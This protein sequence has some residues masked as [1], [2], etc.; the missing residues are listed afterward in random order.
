MYPDIYF[1]RDFAKVYEEVEGGKAYHLK[2]ATAN[3]V[4]ENNVIL[5]E[6]PSNLAGGPYY[7]LT[8][9]Y[10]YGGPLITELKGKKEAL[11]KDY[12]QMMEEFVCR[13]KVVSEFVRFHPL[14]KNQQ[15]FKSIYP[16]QA[17]SM[18]VATRISKEDTFS[19]QFSRSARKTVRKALRK[20]V[21]YRIVK[22]PDDIAEFKAIYF[23]TMDRNQADDFYY[24]DESYFEKLAAEFKEH[25]LLIEISY[26]KKVVA[27]ALYFVYGDI[28]QAHL[29]GTLT[30]YLW[31]SPA[32]LI[33]YA[34]TQWAQKHRIKW[35]HQGGGRTNSK[36]DPLYRFK[37]RFSQTT[38]PIFFVG[39]K[40]WNNAIY[41][42]LLA[43]K[44]VDESSDF[45]PLYRLP[46]QK[47]LLVLGGSRISMQIVKKAQKKG[48]FT[49]VTDWYPYKDSPAKQI[50]DRCYQVST[51]APEA[52]L[53]LIKKEKI[54]GILT[55]FTDSALPHYAE[56]C[57]LAGLPCY[58]SKELFEL[59]THKERYKKLCR[60]YQIP[61]IDDYHLSWDEIKAGCLPEELQFPL[62]VKPADN[63][64]GRGVSICANQKEL[65]TAYRQALEL[66]ESKTVLVER[67]MEGQEAT[68]FFLLDQGQVYLSAIGNR[69]I[70]KNQGKDTIALPVAYTFPAAITAK[71]I[72]ETLPKMKQMFQD[73]GIRDGMMFVQC[74]V[75]NDQCI[76]YDMGYRLT[77]SLEYFLQK[78]I[79]GFDPLEMLI[80]FAFSNQ[81]VTDQKVKERIQPFWQEY[82][83]NLSFLIQ[84]EKEIQAIEGRK[85]I[86]QHPGVIAAVL[87]HEEGEQLT[88]AAKGTL[89]QIVLRVLGK[90]NSMTD[91]K[92]D[93]AQ[94]Y[95]M[96]KVRDTTGENILLA[97]LDVREITGK[98]VKEDDC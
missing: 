49:V 87:A 80:D 6:I 73:V 2:T 62:L 39:K 37:K 5:R 79:C 33:R 35:I 10:G 1:A 16:I 55:G 43:E 91:L 44:T 69:H 70:K 93:L 66:S 19:Q 76:L 63:S 77:G 25:L 4:I 50:A 94:I 42:Q 85:E 7:D 68:V 26:E 29:S 96:L 82:G 31:L 54:S 95:D 45:F 65:R 86:L 30:D 18:T 61:V 92:K 21:S 3:G 57:D 84:T 71:Y 14:V 60:T 47:R 20:G 40:I 24:F 46:E 11:I 51:A 89:Q 9:P 41:Q 83:Y 27:A 59:F 53:Q 88:A 38:D 75:E 72:K 74:M 81:M 48:I 23:A 8:T 12:Q 64:G 97:G 15:D 34:V 78:E 58:G 67:F 22:G 17:S 32:Y 28:I 90:A 13:H 52:L 98:V 36:E 56:I